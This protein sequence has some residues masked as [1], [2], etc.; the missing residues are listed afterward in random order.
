MA[1]EPRSHLHARIGQRVRQLRL[2]RGLTQFQL[3]SQI[4][5]SN[6]FISGIERGVDSPSL[7]T[8]ELLSQALGTT[9]A[10]LVAEETRPEDMYTYDL[11][12]LLRGKRDPR[13]LR[14]LR[15]VVALYDSD[16]KPSPKA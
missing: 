5:C 8:L 16:A 7:T 1:P 2:D 9:V 14:V 6:H 10:A 13:L 11:A 15:E 4:G 3:A 12:Q